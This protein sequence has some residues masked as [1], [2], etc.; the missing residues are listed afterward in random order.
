[1]SGSL[2]FAIVLACAA[3]AGAAGFAFWYQRRIRRQMDT[4][5][6]RLDRAIGG[7]IQ[8][9]TYDESIESAV[10]QRL[11]QLVEMSRLNCDQADKERN[12]VKA[13]ISDISHQVRTPLTNIMLYAGL[14]EEQELSENAGEMASRIHRQADKLDFFMKE[15]VR[16]SYLETDMITVHVEKSSVDELIARACQAVEMQALKKEIVIEAAPS[17]EQA[18]F[19]MKWTVEALVNL[20]DNAV[21]YSP[22]GSVVRICAVPYESFLCIRVKDEGIGIREEEQGMIFRRFYRSP[23]VSGE[24]GLGIGLYLVREI[25]KKQA[26]YVKVKAEPGVGAEFFVYLR[27]D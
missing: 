11:N 15:L 10:T 3:L 12:L 22:V 9:N 20:L 17:S 16:S 18:F 27:R 25:I 4:V 8:E 13:L 7:T 2:V 5:L 14:L 1:M 6:E 19:D 23:S 26:G 21:K 24:K